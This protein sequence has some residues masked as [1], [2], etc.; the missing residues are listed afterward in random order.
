VKAWLGKIPFQ[1]L[2]IEVFSIVLAVLLALGV[3]QWREQEANEALART[4]LAN[5]ASELESNL[6]LLTLINTNN[7]AALESISDQEDDEPVVFVPGLQLQ[8]IAWESLLSTG[9][10]TYVDYSTILMIS[11]TYS[12]QDVYKGLGAQVTQAE[13][14]ATAFSVAMGTVVDDRILRSEFV[15]YFELLVQIELQLLE[16]YGL[17]ME[18]LKMR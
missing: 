17:A 12:I 1:K 16:S 7:A 8:E 13:M 15:G 14:T 10:S 9:V 5:V 3:N 18:A 6:K 4:A 2:L 11:E